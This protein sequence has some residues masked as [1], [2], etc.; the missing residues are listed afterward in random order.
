[1][2]ITRVQLT[3]RPGKERPEGSRDPLQWRMPGPKAQQQMNLIVHAMNRVCGACIAGTL[4][5]RL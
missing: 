1:M 4:S 5:L 3:L 2:Q